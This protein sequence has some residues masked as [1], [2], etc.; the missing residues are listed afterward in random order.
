MDNFGKIACRYDFV[1]DLVVLLLIG[2]SHQWSF[3][4]KRDELC[5]LQDDFSHL[6]LEFS[7]KCMHVQAVK[8]ARL[9][10]ILTV[11][12]IL[13]TIVS[14][15]FGYGI[16]LLEVVTLELKPIVAFTSIFLI[17]FWFYIGT[18]FLHGWILCAQMTCNL[19]KST[20]EIFLDGLRTKVI[21]KNTVRFIKRTKRTSK[22]L[23]PVYFHLSIC[24]F[25]A[26]TFR[27]YQLIDFGFSQSP[28]HVLIYVSIVTQIFGIGLGHL[29]LFNTQ[30]EDVKKQF[31]SIVMR[32][33]SKQSFTVLEFGS[34]INTTSLDLLCAISI[35]I[36]QKISHQVCGL[37]PK[38][39]IR[40]KS[41]STFKNPLW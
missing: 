13:V 21:L 2:F 27:V 36:L 6:N 23:S 17:I 4:T 18:S 22:L 26:L 19:I 11:I 32:K 8:K 16:Q 40:N 1:T 3:M 41:I 12:Y 38:S 20:E 31:K 14:N 33:V 5:A 7:K 34:K 30:S 10:C 24:A 39:V 35:L 28:R 9:S 25:Y 37:R 29:W 15:F